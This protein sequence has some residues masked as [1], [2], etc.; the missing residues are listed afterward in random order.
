LGTNLSDR[1]LQALTGLLPNH[2][3]ARM[4]AFRDAYEHH[5]LLRV[6]GDGIAETEAYLGSIFPS[7]TGDFFA[8]D[9]TEAAAAYRH[10]YAVGGAAVRYRAVHP[11]TVENIVALDLAF[12][13]NAEDW[14]ETLPAE[15]EP[16][17]LGRVRCGHFFCHVF[18]YDYII[19]KGSDWLDI[20]RRIIAYL[21]GR[22][23]EFPSEHN[24]GHLYRA[25][26]VLAAFYKSLDPTNSLNP[27]IGQTSKKRRWA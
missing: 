10:R 6:D 7:A 1:L 12:P 16:Y 8:C 4:N 13:R 25:K 9:E 19:R 23:I 2:L 27:G 5:L 24:V 18:H 11:E 17:V 21:D 15:L 14:R 20:E 26:P 3:P 22:G